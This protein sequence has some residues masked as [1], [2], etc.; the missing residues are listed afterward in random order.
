MVAARATALP[1]AGAKSFARFAVPPFR[2]CLAAASFV[3]RLRRR[4]RRPRRSSCPKATMKEVTR[5]LSSDEFEGRAPGTP[6]EDKTIAYLAERFAK[7]GL[8]PGNNGSWFQD[9]PLV[10]IAASN[11]EPLTIAG[12]SLRLRQRLGRG[13]V[14]RS[15]ADGSRRE[16]D[17]VR[18]LR[19]ERARE[20]LERLRRDR[21]A[22]EDRADPGQRSPT[23]RP[24]G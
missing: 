4:I 24:R 16:R 11:F 22:R 3:L 2:L 19:H 10:E 6:G 17:R 21:H 7:A 8:E 5:V 13:D 9:V 14:P 15:A 1:K 20:G 12:K 23:G 18:R